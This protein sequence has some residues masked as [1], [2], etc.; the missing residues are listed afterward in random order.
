MLSGDEN[1]PIGKSGQRKKNTQSQGKKAF[2]RRRKSAQPQELGQDQFQDIPEAISAPVTSTVED[3]P[4]G[5]LLTERSSAELPDSFAD[6]S[7]PSVAVPSE[8]AVPLLP[9]EAAPFPS[10]GATPVPSAEAAA[11]SYQTI[12]NAYCNYTLQ[13]FDQIRCFFEKLAAVR[14]PDKALELQTEFARL[15]YEGFAAESQ[16]IHELHGELAKQRVKR[17]E[18]FVAWMIGPSLNPV[19][20]AQAVA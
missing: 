15:A 2:S 3:A 4:P 10:T 18:D 17:W 8:E 16:K 13:S 20:Q 5:V 12:A 9:A 1:K 7:V 19:R 6:D 11:V 14:S